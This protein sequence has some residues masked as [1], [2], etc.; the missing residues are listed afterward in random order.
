[1]RLEN[2]RRAALVSGVATAMRNGYAQFPRLAIDS[3]I[4][5]FED[6]LDPTKKFTF[7]GTFAQ[8]KYTM[9]DNSEAAII[10]DF[11]LDNFADIQNN[12]KEYNKK[13]NPVNLS[14]IQEKN[15]LREVNERIRYQL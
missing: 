7:R 11:L 3:I 4:A 15:L 5:G 6:I 12:L 2:A 9:R 13:H 8:M 14:K 1:M 10:S